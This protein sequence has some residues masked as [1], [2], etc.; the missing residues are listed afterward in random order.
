MSFALK[1]CEEFSTVYIDDILIFSQTREEHLKHLEKVFKCLD[2]ESYHVRLPKCLFLQKEVEFLGHLLTANGLQASPNKM[3]ALKVWQPPF[4]KAKHVKQFLVLV[5]WYKSF[6]PHM[7]TI[8][9]PLFPLTSTTKRFEWSEAATAAVR[10]LQQQV[11]QAP[12]LAR[13]DPALPTRVVTDASKVGIGA[14]LE[15][16][17]DTG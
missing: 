3:E 12:C 6:I 1:G 7:A 15:Q 17:H 10:T 14:V 8:A 4:Q 13:W 2:Q 16:K 11:S 9:A 5:L